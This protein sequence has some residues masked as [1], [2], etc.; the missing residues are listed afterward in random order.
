MKQV[1]PTAWVRALAERDWRPGWSPRE[2]RV[3]DVCTQGVLAGQFDSV[4][5]AAQVCIDR[6]RRVNSGMPRRSWW[7]VRSALKRRLQAAGFGGRIAKWTPEGDRVVRRYA[8]A[9][10]RHR[11]RTVDE[12]SRACAGELDRLRREQ[13]AGSPEPPPSSRTVWNRLYR[14]AKIAGWTRP[15]TRQTAAALR[16]Y[17]RYADRFV[18][19]GFRS[20]R[21]AARACIEFLR[22]RSRSSPG[23][24]PMG[25]A[26]LCEYLTRRARES[27]L[28]QWWSRWSA[29]EM[30]VINRYVAAIQR[31]EYSRMYAAGA[32]CYRELERLRRSGPAR[33]WTA[34]PR[35]EKAVTACICR[36]LQD[37]HVVTCRSAWTREESG[38]LRRYA[39]ALAE[40]H[41]RDATKAATACRAELLARCQAGARRYAPRA[42]KS[43]RSR[44]TPMARKFGW[45]GACG[46]L[47]PEEERLLGLFVRKLARKEYASC[48]QAAPACRAALNRL[49]RRQPELRPKAVTTI[50]GYLRRRQGGRRGNEGMR[51]NK[52]QP[53]Y[54][55]RPRERR[56]ND[57]RGAMNAERRKCSIACGSQYRFARPH[58]PPE[59]A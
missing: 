25:L 28:P 11:F 40:R 15:T 49:C 2:N 44:L 7:A 32:D 43:V 27:G 47:H 57:E 9:L 16:V 12:A 1:M 14:F 45:R 13:P 42:L 52:G 41:Y 24:A 26:H 37:L 58:E 8:R 5:A 30:K 38:L 31:N 4:A 54:S 10:L 50:Y 56:R 35:S 18:A 48:Y 51:G 39:R 23:V 36:R 46:R 6:L 33:R 20:M 17:D 29:D 59:S 22:S 19:G 21:A 53:A 34:L 3:L 55:S